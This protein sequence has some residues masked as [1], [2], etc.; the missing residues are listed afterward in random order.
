MLAI[1]FDVAPASGDSWINYVFQMKPQT[2]VNGVK[3]GNRAGQ[4]LGTLLLNQL[5]L[6]YCIKHSVTIRDVWVRAPSNKKI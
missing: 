4:R 2:K 3:S 1:V 6:K 5:H